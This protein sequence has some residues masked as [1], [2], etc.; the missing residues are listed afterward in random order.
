MRGHFVSALAL[1]S[2]TAFAAGSIVAAIAE[3][4]TINGNNTSPMPVYERQLVKWGLGDGY[5]FLN[6]QSP[7]KEAEIMQIERQKKQRSL[8]N[9]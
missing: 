6:P 9:H 7:G 8:K 2:F 3:P 4:T 1:S 5:C